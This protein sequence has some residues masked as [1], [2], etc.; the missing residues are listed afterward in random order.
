MMGE[1]VLSLLTTVVSLKKLS[2]RTWRK[3]AARLA[4][5]L[6]VFNI[7]VQWNGLPID[8]DGTIHLS[9]AEFSL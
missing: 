4:W 9:I 7:V 8:A 5:T 3:V 6:A 1:T 2:H